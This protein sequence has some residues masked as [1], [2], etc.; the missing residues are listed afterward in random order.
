MANVPTRDEHPE[1]DDTPFLSEGM[2]SKYRGIIGSVNWVVTLGQFDALYAT[3]TLA[4]FSMSPKENR[5]LMAKRI[6]GS[7]KEYPNFCIVL[8][9]KPLNIAGRLKNFNEYES[10]TEFYPDAAEEFPR[11]RPLALPV[12][13][14]AQ[15]T[16]FVDA[17]HAHCE[18]TRRSVTGII[19]F[20]NSTPVKWCSKM[21]RTVEPSTY[22]S[23]LVAARIATD[24][25]MEFRYN[26]R[27][28][29]FDLDGLLRYW[30]T[31]TLWFSILLSQV[32]N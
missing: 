28:R 25:A 1:I 30:V 11:N 7:L 2:A 29:G 8:N 23:E 3:T 19:V 13:K 22:V 10:W 4:R 9:P 15:I 32:P 26:V 24:F 27:M 31:T 5:L 12:T 21:Q 14:P 6:L 18:I 20:I 16:I 17:D